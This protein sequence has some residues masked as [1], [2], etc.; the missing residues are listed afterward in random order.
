M[1]QHHTSGWETRQ[2]PITTDE[3]RAQFEGAVVFETHTDEPIRRTHVFPPVVWDRTTAE[4]FMA[5]QR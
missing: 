4:A 2:G 1:G 3:A 5:S